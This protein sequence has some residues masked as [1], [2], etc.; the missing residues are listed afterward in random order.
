MVKAEPRVAIVQ[1]WSCDPK[2]LALRTCLRSS[3]PVTLEYKWPEFPVLG[4]QGNPPEVHV[5]SRVLTGCAHQDSGVCPPTQGTG[6]SSCHTD[7]LIPR[8]TRT[9]RSSISL[10]LFLLKHFASA[11]NLSG[12]FSVI[13]PFYLCKAHLL[14]THFMHSLILTAFC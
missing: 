3:C 8:T 9:Q 7:V 13:F 6:F 1:K 10:P 4:L 14:F 5:T 11:S 12:L 2:I